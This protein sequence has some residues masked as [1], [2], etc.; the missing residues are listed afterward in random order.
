MGTDMSNKIKLEMTWIG[1]ENR[2]KADNMTLS[3]LAGH[4]RD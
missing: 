1:K 4:S 2:P 3:G